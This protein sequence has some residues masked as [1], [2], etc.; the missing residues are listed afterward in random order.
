MDYEVFRLLLD[1]FVFVHCHSFIPPGVCLKCLL[2]IY[3]LSVFACQ[4]ILW[5]FSGESKS[6]TAKS[7]LSGRTF[8][9]IG[10]GGAGKAIAYGAKHRGAE[11]FIANRS[12]GE[13]RPGKWYTLSMSQNI[14]IHTPL[15]LCNIQ[16][17]PVPILNIWACGCISAHF[18]CFN[19]QIETSETMQTHLFPASFVSFFLKNT[20]THFW[21]CF[22]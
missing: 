19:L 6:S 10:A 18:K 20:S 16:L 22:F 13:Y 12:F 7:P 11:V 5:S 9:V 21:N 4:L 3:G 2:A 17:T 15:T 8:V 1:V 14:Y